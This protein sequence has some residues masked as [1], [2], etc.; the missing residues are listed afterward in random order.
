M[1][2]CKS[3]HA[4]YGIGN[5]VVTQIRG[6]PCF[7]IEP[8]EER[9]IGAPN[10][11]A[12]IVDDMSAKPP[13]RVWSFGF[14][15]SGRSMA[16]PASVA[17]CYGELPSGAAAKPAPVLKVGVLY[18]VFLNA[19]PQDASDPIHGYD[20]DFCLVAAATGVEVVQVRSES[21]AWQ[22]TSVCPVTLKPAR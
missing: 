3:A 6:K 22:D 18:S 11:S 16:I 1:A 8:K 10:L 21:G 15:P 20:A 13:V 19:R 7:S 9:R 12:L 14:Q 4:T 2:T 17:I 5:A